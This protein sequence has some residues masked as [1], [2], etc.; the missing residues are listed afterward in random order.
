MKV[1]RWE[2]DRVRKGEIGSGARVV[3]EGMRG[4]GHRDDG[5]STSRPLSIAFCL[6]GKAFGN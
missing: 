1:R 2:G 4:V 6:R 3:S 5:M